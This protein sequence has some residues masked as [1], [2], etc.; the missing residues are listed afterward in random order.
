M[1]VRVAAVRLSRCGSRADGWRS[2]TAEAPPRP[3]WGAG[4]RRGRGPD[5]DGEPRLDEGRHGLPGAARLG[6][7]V[8]LDHG[9]DLAVGAVRGEEHLVRVL[10]A[11]PGEVHQEVVV[12]RHGELDLGDLRV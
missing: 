5:R 2:G 6:G 4:P 8:A 10:Q 3:G 1:R 9:L 7:V 12:V 11:E